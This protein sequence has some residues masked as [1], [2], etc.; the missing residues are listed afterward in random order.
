MPQIFNAF[1]SQVKVNDETIEGL[2]SIDF[3]QTKS[4]QDVGAIG[5]D[6]RIAVYFGLKQV[7]GRLRVASANATLDKLLQDNARFSI[8]AALKH[9]DQARNLSFDDCYLDDK[10]FAMSAQGHG[11]TVY[12]FTA[13]R[14][15]EE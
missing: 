1:A 4:R 9:G 5:T 3:A 14:L 15:R 10:Q 7:S 11:E 6:E 2:Q 8:T 12:A 13:T